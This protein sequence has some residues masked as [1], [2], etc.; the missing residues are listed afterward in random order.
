VDQ[1]YLGSRGA[2][3]GILLMWDRWVVMKIEDCM[4]KFSVVCSFRS[5]ID[6]VEWAFAEVYG[7]NNDVDRRYL[8]EELV[9]IISWWDPPLCIGGDFNVVSS[10]SSGSAGWIVIYSAL[11]T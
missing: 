1:K 9:G 2:S 11:S 3:S 10:K 8:W 5:A 7:P 4:G 6:N